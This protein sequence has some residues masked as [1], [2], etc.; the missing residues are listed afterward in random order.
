MSNTA[1]IAGWRQR[2]NGS[3]CQFLRQRVRDS[4]DIEDLAQ[5]TWLRLLRV[6]DLSAVRNPHAYLLQVAYHVIL[7]WRGQRLPPEAC[8]GIEDAALVD[9]CAPELELEAELSEQR[10]ERALAA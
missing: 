3:L 6:R 7:E 8:V 1:L 9:D 2:W 4:V 5:E 10:I